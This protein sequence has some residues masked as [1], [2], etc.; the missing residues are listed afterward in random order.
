MGDLTLGRS[1]MGQCSVCTDVRE[2][3]QC[4]RGGVC[5]CCVTG[6]VPQCHPELQHRY[7]RH[8]HLPPAQRRCLRALLLDLVSYQLTQDFV[9]CPR[10]ADF[11]SSPPEVFV[12]AYALGC[13]C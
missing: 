10:E 8:W 12:L 11:G 3:G 13:R 6:A 7:E 4:H 1:D 9:A 2:P 5:E